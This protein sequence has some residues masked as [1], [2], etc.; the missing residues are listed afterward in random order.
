MLW[1]ASAGKATV[2]LAGSIHVL[3][4][5]DYPLPS[6]WRKAWDDAA[7]VVMETK[8]GTSENPDVQKE[9]MALST[10]PAEQSLPNL[11]SPETK[12]ALAAWCAE[13]GV[14]PESFRQTKPWMA[15]LRIGMTTLDR[16]GFSAARGIERHLGAR[17]GNRRTDGLETTAE[18][19]GI[20]DSLSPSEQDQLVAT[21]I[22][23]ARTAPNRIAQ[24]ASA[25]HEGDA[26]T[27]DRL[28]REG[29][30]DFPQLRRRLMDDRN[31]AWLPKIRALLAGSETAMVIVG[32]GHLCGPD[33]L[34]D[35]LAREGV[36]LSQQECTTRRPAP[37][38][39]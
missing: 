22:R 14:A 33:S 6:P 1:K 16:L 35:L 13:S 18:S 26:A 32:S 17:L 2:W 12:N 10:L 7:I 15:S 30:K 8:P 28:L 3:R 38:T 19:L 21:A 37:A 39:P 9:A 11:L 20:L 31:A 4:N 36:S 29:F 34:I 27:L 23:D 25:W 5:S 24:L